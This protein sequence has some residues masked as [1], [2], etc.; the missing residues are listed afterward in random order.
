[1]VRKELSK[2]RRQYFTFLSEEGYEYVNRSGF[3][4]IPQV[5]QSGR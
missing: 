1:L 3:R 5:S 4:L 2:A